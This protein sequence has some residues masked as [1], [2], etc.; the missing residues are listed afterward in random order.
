[1]TP[2]ETF[3]QGPV[4]EGQESA[5]RKEAPRSVKIVS[6]DVGRWKINQIFNNDEYAG[7]IIHIDSKEGSKIGIITVELKDQEDA[8]EPAAQRE[9]PKLEWLKSTNVLKYEPGQRYDDDENNI[10]GIVIGRN[11]TE[12]LIQ[13]R[14]DNREEA[15][16]K[17]V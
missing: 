16:S 11:F 8:P 12:G 7:R 5:A 6:R 14:H 13:V 9:A 15:G 3:D 2:R 17:A 10:H 1:M 4:Q